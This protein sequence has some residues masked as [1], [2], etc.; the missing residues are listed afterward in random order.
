MTDMA[1]APTITWQTAEYD[2]TSESAWLPDGWV[3]E[4]G[5]DGWL[6]MTPGGECQGGGCATDIEDA[7]RKCIACLDRR[8]A[9][10]EALRPRRN[11]THDAVRALTLARARYIESKHTDHTALASWRDA[12]R[13]YRELTGHDHP[14]A[15][16]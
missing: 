7:K 9:V 13:Q 4:A 11:L 2:D 16:R 6:V 15:P 8:A 5:A 3:L 1:A 14:Q 10:D 12:S